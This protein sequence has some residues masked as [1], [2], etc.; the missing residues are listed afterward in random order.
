[1]SSRYF[2]PVEDTVSWTLRAVFP[3]AVG[4]FATYKFSLIMEDDI[5]TR[6]LQAQDE[7]HWIFPDQDNTSVDTTIEK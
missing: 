4:A 1:M 5:Y 6:I 7:Q 3:F 2:S